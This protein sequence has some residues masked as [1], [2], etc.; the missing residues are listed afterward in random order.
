MRKYILI[1]LFIIVSFLIYKIHLT[2]NSFWAEWTG[3]VDKTLF[4]LLEKIIIPSLIPI[5]VA[6]SVYLLIRQKRKELRKSKK[7]I[8]K[9]K[10]F[11]II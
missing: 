11:E 6:I 1:I 7:G 10:F 8:G 9:K 2:E 4:D 3:F 5:S